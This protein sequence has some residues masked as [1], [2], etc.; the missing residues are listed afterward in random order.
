MRVELISRHCK[1]LDSCHFWFRA[2]NSDAK[3]QLDTKV[4]HI[5]EPGSMEERSSW[6]EPQLLSGDRRTH[7]YQVQFSPP[8]KQE[9]WL[10][11]VFGFCFFV[12]AQNGPMFK[13][14]Q[15]CVYLFR[16]RNVWDLNTNVPILSY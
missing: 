7:S 12:F 16:P 15:L 2:T 13:C 4:V 1:K 5:R 10:L 6:T 3:D 9:I 11:L 8:K 14:G